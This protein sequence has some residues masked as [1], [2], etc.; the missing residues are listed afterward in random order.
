MTLAGIFARIDAVWHK[1]THPKHKISWKDDPI[2][3]D[4]YFVCEGDIV[5]KTC[6]KLFWCRYYDL[7]KSKRSKIEEA[8]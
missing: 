8:V 2:L 6:N 1:I 7:S 5:C 4:P 3:D